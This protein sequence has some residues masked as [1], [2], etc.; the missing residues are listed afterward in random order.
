MAERVNAPVLKTEMAPRENDVS[1]VE[2]RIEPNETEALRIKKWQQAGNRKWRNGLLPKVWQQRFCK[3]ESGPS[4]SLPSLLRCSCSERRRLSDNSRKFVISFPSTR[5]TIKQCVWSHSTGARR[6]SK[7]HL[8]VVLSKNLKG[9]SGSLH[10]KYF[11]FF[12]R[13]SQR[14]FG[15]LLQPSP[16]FQWLIS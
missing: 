9:E 2:Q 13:P 1:L 12:S 5:S 4:Q 10:L 8:S 3:P 16:S 14:L 6:A 7:T 11:S 15:S